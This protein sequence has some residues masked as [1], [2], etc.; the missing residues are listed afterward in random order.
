MDR[1][2]SARLRA[3][4]HRNHGLLCYRTDAENT[5]RIVVPHDEVLKYRILDEVHDAAIGG[6]MGREKTYGLV[7]MSY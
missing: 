1:R 7:N 6:H 4:L 2:L 5:P 3:K